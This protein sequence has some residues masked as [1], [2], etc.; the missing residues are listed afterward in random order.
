MLAALLAT[1]LIA[2]VPFGPAFAEDGTPP[3]PHGER[4]DQQ[5][6]TCLERLGEWRGVQETNLGRAAEAIDRI[7]EVLE[8]AEGL[9]ID[10]SEGKAL[11]AEMVSLLATANQHHDQAAAILDAHSGYDGD[12]SVV[13]RE[14]AGD[15]C[16]TGRDALA[17]GRDALLDL[18]GLGRELRQLAREWRQG[19]LQAPASEGG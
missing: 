11:L 18:R 19:L 7:E 6:E 17:N 16:R 1:A 15:T 14:Q 5:L 12:G 2:S 4:L 8:K 9:G 3:P 13:D 10:V